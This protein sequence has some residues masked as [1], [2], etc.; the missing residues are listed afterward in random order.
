MTGPEHYLKAEA[1]IETLNKVSRDGMDISASAASALLAEAQ[2]H[3]TLAQAAV[4][5]MGLMTEAPWREVDMWYG[6]IVKQD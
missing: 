2:V 5:A 6:A 3:A 1:I 4:A